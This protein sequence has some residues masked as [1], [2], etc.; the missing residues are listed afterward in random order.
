M[1]N[2]EYKLSKQHQ[3]TKLREAANYRT[4]QEVQNAKK[5]LLPFRRNRRS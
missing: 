1:T 2:W 3:Q 5:E 4:A